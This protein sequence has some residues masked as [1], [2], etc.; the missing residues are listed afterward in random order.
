[1]ISSK[2]LIYYN[3][4]SFTCCLSFVVLFNIKTYKIFVFQNILDLASDED[5]ET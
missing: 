4:L 5:D 1:M 2:F 3:E